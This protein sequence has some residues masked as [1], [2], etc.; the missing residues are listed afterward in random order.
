MSFGLQAGEKVIVQIGRSEPKVAVFDGYRCFKYTVRDFDYDLFPILRM[1]A[2]NG[3][4]LRISVL[5]KDSFV[6]HAFSDIVSLRRYYT[7]EQI[8]KAVA[9]KNEALA[10]IDPATELRKETDG[11]YG[12]YSV[13]TGKLQTIIYN[14]ELLPYLKDY[15]E[16]E[17]I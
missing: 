12:I 16:S 15:L 9:R 4:M 13:K 14:E 3:G 11:R 10:R 5:G 6:C 7:P 2:K 1:P 17:K 8:E